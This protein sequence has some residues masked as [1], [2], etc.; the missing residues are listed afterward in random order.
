[1][2]VSNLTPRHHTAAKVVQLYSRRMEIEEGFR[3]IKSERFEF[4]FN[5]HGTR[6]A[7]RI[8]IL[9]LI[10]MLAS[11]RLLTS[12]LSLDRAGKAPAIKA[13]RVAHGEASRFGDWAVKPSWPAIPRAEWTD[14]SGSCDKKPNWGSLYNSW[15]GL[16]V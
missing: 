6:H 12:G 5:L 14:S 13:I 3:D 11:F 7:R 9:L 10:A 16:R 8:E 1:M 4:A 2:L 15:G